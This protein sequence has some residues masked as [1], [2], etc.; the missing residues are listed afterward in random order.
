MSKKEMCEEEPSMKSAI[1]IPLYLAILGAMTFSGCAAI[2]EAVPIDGAGNECLGAGSERVVSV[3]RLRIV[4]ANGDVR[5]VLG[6]DDGNEPYFELVGPESGAV[7]RIETIGKS[8]I[9]SLGGGDLGSERMMQ[10]CASDGYVRMKLQR[11][12]S[13]WPWESIE[14]AGVVVV[15]T[16]AEGPSV[17]VYQEGKGDAVLGPKDQ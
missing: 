10:L 6:V 11:G 13:K 15:V 1:L 2:E 8:A 12:R 5:I 4:D 16:D 17:T 14:D 9:L 7:V 3:R